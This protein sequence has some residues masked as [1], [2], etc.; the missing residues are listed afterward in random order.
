[1]LKQVRDSPSLPVAALKQLGASAILGSSAALLALLLGCSDMPG[2]ARTDA[3]VNPSPTQGSPVPVA[4]SN[5]GLPILYPSYLPAGYSLVRIDRHD[6]ISDLQFLFGPQGT[7]AG[8]R[9]G[10]Y[11]TLGLDTATGLF[12]SGTILNPHKRITIRGQPAILLQ[13]SME[14]VFSL[15]KGGEENRPTGNAG[16]GL[17]FSPIEVLGLET[18]LL[19]FS[20]SLY[21]IPPD[22]SDPDTIIRIAESLMLVGGS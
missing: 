15:V 17:T 5:L 3:Q 22:S 10:P 13:G 11:I 21:A 6:R 1:M 18:E 14:P 20:V 9:R 12:P 8:G 4:V 2:E 19:G 16:E 7:S